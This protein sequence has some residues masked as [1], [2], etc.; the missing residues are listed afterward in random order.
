M[1]IQS[2]ALLLG[3]A[4]LMT[5]CGSPSHAPSSASARAA[6]A[7]T[8]TA[9]NTTAARRLSRKERSEQ[10]A[11]ERVQRVR[12]AREERERGREAEQT[13]RET[14][15]REAE[16]KATE[17]A[18]KLVEVW[19]QEPASASDSD[20]MSIEHDL[21]ALSHKCR[22]DIPTLAGEINSGVEILSKEGIH[23]TPAGLAAG[24]DKAAPGRKVSPDCRGV[25]AALL[26]LMEQEHN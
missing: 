17:S 19:R 22:E 6:V 14:Q 24:L 20:V 5:G 18:K 9:T 3:S 10:R 4:A 21:L 23:E 16:E 2:A 25:L 1:R 13:A 26:T 11:R 7:N 15:A 12:E 8:T